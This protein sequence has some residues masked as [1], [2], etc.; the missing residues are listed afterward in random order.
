MRR[1]TR[2]RSEIYKNMFWTPVYLSHRFAP[3]STAPSA[4][5]SKALEFMILY[6]AMICKSDSTKKILK[7]YTATPN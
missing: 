2:G 7:L 4:G 5:Q 6:F 1:Q 3:T